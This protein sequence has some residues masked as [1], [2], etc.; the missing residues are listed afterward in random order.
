M[1]REELL[2]LFDTTITNC[3]NQMSAKNNDYAG[4]DDPLKNFHSYSMVGVDPRKGILTRMVDK[5]S[6]L[7][8][9][10]EDKEMKVADEKVD[11]TIEDLIN[12]A[13]LLRATFHGPRT[14]MHVSDDGRTL[15]N[16]RFIRPFHHV[17]IFMDNDSTDDGEDD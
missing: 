2:T 4:D 6:R 3:R 12:Y 10:A 14:M 13:V 1:T 17:G 8:N 15:I 16:G 5:L 9:F 11:D 7:S